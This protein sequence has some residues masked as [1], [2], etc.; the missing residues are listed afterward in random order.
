MFTYK[1]MLLLLVVT[2]L[3]ACTSSSKLLQEGNYDASI[4]KSIKKLM[5]HPDKADE[6]ATL[7]KAWNLANSEDSDKINKLKLLNRPEVWDDIYKS[8]VRLDD[9]QKKVSR[10]PD[11]VLSKIGFKQIDYTAEQAATMEKAVSYYYN[12]AIE[13]LQSENKQDARQAWKELMVIK[14]YL[15]DYKDVNKLLDEA[16]LKGTNYILFQIKNQSITV[17]P[18]HY[19]EQIEKMNIA[20]L[21][22]Q[23]LQFETHKSK[24]LYYDYEIVLGITEINVSPELVEKEKTE[25]TK[26]VE[27]G[28]EYVLDANGNVAKDSLGNDIKRTKYKLLKAFITKYHLNKKAEVKGSLNYYNSYSKNLVK[29]IPIATEYVFNYD[30]ATCEGD[31][32]ALTKD[33]EALIN[34]GAIPFPT[35][36]EIIFDTSEELK[37]IAFGNIKHDR[38]LFMN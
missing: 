19:E 9:R 31:K 34:K 12:H 33:T 1:S 36:S 30:Y 37:R 11:E 27:D 5:K 17:L 10:L 20:S 15:P 2:I 3:S 14:K 29:T 38:D 24:Y 18:K 8:Y 4:G 6:I 28:W 26:R 32:A 16:I 22:E 13:L 23:W 35:D 21:N 7:K 25:E